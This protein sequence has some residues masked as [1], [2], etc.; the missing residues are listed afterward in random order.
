M[1]KKSE[2]KWRRKRDGVEEVRGEVCSLVSAS[3][4]TSLWGKENS[5]EGGI[6]CV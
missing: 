4:K 1:V 5:W 6:G 2:I 3:S